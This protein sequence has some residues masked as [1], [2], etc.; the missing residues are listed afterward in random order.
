[1]RSVVEAAGDRELDTTEGVRIIEG[2][3]SWVLVLPDPSE[4]VTH[5]W[6][7]GPDPARA[8]ALLQ[9]WGDVVEGAGR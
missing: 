6:A 2:D 8:S 9:I 1:M 7:E 5:L 3:G 4:A